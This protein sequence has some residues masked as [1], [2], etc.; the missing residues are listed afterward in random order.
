MAAY[1]SEAYRNAY[2]QGMIA[3]KAYDEEGNPIYYMQESP[4]ITVTAHRPTVKE[5]VGKW[6]YNITAPA[7]AG[8]QTVLST[9]A[10]LIGEILQGSD[11]N[12]WRAV[13]KAA[14]DIWWPEY[15]N[16]AGRTG[17][18]SIL[19]AGE[20]DE[21]GIRHAADWKGKAWNF[22]LD[23]AS[24]P[25]SYVGA[26]ALNNFFKAPGMVTGNVINDAKKSLSFAKRVPYYLKHLNAARKVPMKELDPKYA[27]YFYSEN[28]ATLFTTTPKAK[29]RI[30][31]MEGMRLF[32]DPISPYS[33]LGNNPEA[34]MF[35]SARDNYISFYKSAYGK[36]PSDRWLNK[37]LKNTKEVLPEETKRFY[38]YME[39]PETL[40]KLQNKIG[41]N[42][43][44][45]VHIPTLTSPQLAWPA[46]KAGVAGRRLG[47]SAV[48]ALLNFNPRTTAWHELTHLNDIFQR[49][50]S[51]ATAVLNKLFDYDAIRRSDP[52]YFTNPHRI[53]QELVA[54][55]MPSKIAKGVG[56]E[57]AEDEIMNALRSTGYR[58]DRFLR[59][60]IYRQ[61]ASL[62]TYPLVRMGTQ[63]APPVYGNEINR[64]FHI[65]TTKTKMDI[66]RGFV[67]QGL[68]TVTGLGI[69]G[70]TLKE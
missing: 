20:V 38:S 66:L 41:V 19:G 31:E 37:A 26:N 56:K 62:R 17:S 40:A 14:R 21:A 5:S 53:T 23:S 9:P 64:I 7:I 28:P 12:Y 32:G 8:A 3:N 18:D 4:E 15:S 25:W 61:P 1:G 67:N 45:G 58:F 70:S 48:T 43:V 57:I 63:G 69:L 34:K 6:A 44:P 55:L 54:V 46:L 49:D 36:A 60:G 10:N 35:K 27:R 16:L 22:I 65:P 30:P 42:Y 59:P 50:P 52:E 47:D 68:P 33:V 13:P 11:A 51:R 39:H 29:V 24:D 2:K